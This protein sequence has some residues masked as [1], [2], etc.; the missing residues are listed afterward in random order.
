[1]TGPVPLTLSRRADLA[2]DDPALRSS[3]RNATSVM[4]VGRLDALARLENPDQLRDAAR[5]ARASTLADLPRLLA[6]WADAFESRGGKVCWAKDA[7]E[8]VAY[9]LTVLKR[10][11]ATTVAKGKSMATEEIHLNAALGAAGINVVETDLGEFIIQ[12][13][14]ETPSHLIAPAIHKNRF[15]VADL[16]SADAG[17]DVPPAIDAEV[18]YARA[19]LR[20][21]F[22]SADVGITGVNFAV[23]EAG[24]ICLVENE[25]NGR[26]CTSL[27]RVHIAVMGMERVVADWA[28]LDV[29]L[30][31]LARS[32][33][34][35]DLTVYTNI[36]SGPRQ[37]GEVD[38]PE[39]MHVIVLDN[40]RSDIL[41]SE[42]Q[43]ALACI[44]CGACLNTCPVYRN[45]GGHAYGSVYAGPIGA[46]LTPLLNQHEPAA[47][48]LAEAS[49]L[50]G[51]CHDVC[52]VRIP[53]HDMLQQLRV[54]HVPQDAPRLRR[55]A[56]RLW[57]LLWSTRGG[58]RTS[59]WLARAALR[60]PAPRRGP[61]WAGAWLSSREAPRRKG[62]KL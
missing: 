60:L 40:A 47:R 58:Y 19:R 13:A 50:C 24:A 57:S 28:E 17:F 2:L 12:L 37:P 8:A 18:A 25:G 38:G 9:V 39:Q 29:M 46:V 15:Q 53:L 56:F 49:S 48:E 6:T 26:L 61:G 11:G 44:R 10:H 4:G 45:I 30:S 5:A 32:A 41:G 52:P 21:S 42:F 31:L 1:M 22:L 34:G 27:P 43:E 35:Q 51:A 7:S 14:G 36:L 16:L 54:R 55:A 59:V 3:V 62:R 33:T 20:E 23:A